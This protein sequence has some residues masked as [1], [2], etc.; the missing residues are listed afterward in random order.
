[1]HERRQMLKQ[2]EIIPR[3]DTDDTA[4]S[5]LESMRLCHSKDMPIKVYS[6]F[7]DNYL[8]QFLEQHGPEANTDKEQ[9]ALEVKLIQAGGVM[10]W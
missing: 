7:H 8:P 2:C 3:W 10:Q 9:Y 1:M 4:D 6:W 5:Q